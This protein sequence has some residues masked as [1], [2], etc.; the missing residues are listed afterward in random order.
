MFD[1]I[2]RQIFDMYLDNDFEGIRPLF[3]DDWQKEYEE[4][5]KFER[6]HQFSGADRTHLECD[7]LNPVIYKSELK[8]FANGFKVA[9][10]L[11]S[12]IYGITK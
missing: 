7:L 1:N 6:K 5:T 2:M 12:E 4:L 8:G 3:Q 10:R 9:V 11:M